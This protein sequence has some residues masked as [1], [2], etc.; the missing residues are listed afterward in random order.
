MYDAVVIGSGPAGYECA[1]KIAELGGKAVVIEK[2]KIGGACTNYG[3]VPTKALHA[4]ALLFVDV[5]NAEKYGIKVPSSAVDFKAL[6]QRKERIVSTLSRGVKKL[7][8]MRHIEIVHGEAKIKDAN[9][10]AVSGRELKTKNIVIATG[11]KPMVLPGITLGGA[12]LGS[13]EILALKE[14]PKSLIIV[15]GGYIGCEFASIFAGLGTKVTIIEKMP[16]ILAAE[17]KDISAELTRLMKRQGIEVLAESS[18]KKI[19]ENKVI[20]EKGDEEKAVSADKILI[21]VGMAPYFDKE[22]M[23]KLRVAYN[24]GIIVNERMQTSV[25]NIY[26]IG[27]VTD[28]LKLAHYAYSQAETAAENI[29]GKDSRFDETVVPSTIFTIPEISSVGVRNSSLK[30]A[31]FLFAANGKARTMD[32]AEGFVKIYYED[33]HLKGFCAIG[34]HASD[35]VSEAALAIKNDIPLEKIKGTI[36]SHL[37]LAEAFLGA[38][39]K[40]LKD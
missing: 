34:P 37:T 35:I 16:S 3:C 6:M 10:V 1:R 30:S 7:L 2:D 12:V 32:K 27:D 13:T 19:E 9:T 21:A 14:L 23:G 4:S 28:K 29:M 38:V 17:D 36:H 22:E 31:I 33:G 40:A 25:A 11:A 5:K 18:I 26:A 15:G 8:E 39:E 24:K 20:F